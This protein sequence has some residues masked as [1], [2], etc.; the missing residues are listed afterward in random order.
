MK[1]DLSEKKKKDFFS[2]ALL[3]K[4]KTWDLSSALTNLLPQKCLQ[5]ECFSTLISFRH[6]LAFFD[7]QRSRFKC[8]LFKALQA[9]LYLLPI[10]YARATT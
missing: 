4:Y 8:R 3:D 5:V 10:L 6:S 7:D 1:D 2:T 9:T